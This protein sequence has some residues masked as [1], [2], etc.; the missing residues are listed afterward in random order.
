MQICIQ[1]QKLLINQPGYLREFHSEKLGL[2]NL[3]RMQQYYSSYNLKCLKP[4]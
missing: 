1:V 2:E 3:F 4:P